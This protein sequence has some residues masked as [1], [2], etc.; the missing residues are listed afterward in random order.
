MLAEIS[1][2]AAKNNA[3]TAYHEG[4]IGSKVY[5]LIERRVFDAISDLPKVQQPLPKLTVS[6]LIGKVPLLNGLSEAL[7]EKL[8]ERVTV[9]QFRVFS[10]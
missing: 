4:A 6:T 10:E 1:L 9:L 3:Y 2:N 5:S 7:I 8:A